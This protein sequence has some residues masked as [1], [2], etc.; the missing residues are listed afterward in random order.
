MFFFLL[1]GQA[2][3][4]E[5]R[6]GILDECLHILN[7]I[8]RKFVYLEPIFSRGNALRGVLF[9]RDGLGGFLGALPKEQGRFR[10][11]DKEFRDIMAEIASNPRLVIFA[12]RKDLSNM[13]KSMLDQL[14]RCQKALN[15]LLE[16]RILFFFFLFTYFLSR[17]NVRSF[18]DFT[19]SVMMI[20]LKF[21]VNQ[22]I[23][24]SFNHI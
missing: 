5:Q 19:S 2:Q 20:Y 6:L 9:W 8:Q 13:L 10:G 17:K 1:E 14:G 23:L 4:W 16:V 21:S 11:V 15:E 24:L 7:Q 3:I 18:L 12:Q 22:L